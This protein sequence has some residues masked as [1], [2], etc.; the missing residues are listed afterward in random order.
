VVVFVTVANA[1][2][3]VAPAVAA[4]LDDSPAVVFLGGEKAVVLR[5]GESGFVQLVDGVLY[6]HCGVDARGLDPG[7]VG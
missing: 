6:S 7:V 4:E 1:G 2:G 5:D 3:L